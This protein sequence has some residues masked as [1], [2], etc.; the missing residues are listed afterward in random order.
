MVSL[1][2]GIVPLTNTNPDSASFV[3]Y[4]TPVSAV[5]GLSIGFDFYS[6]GGTGA[7]GISF[8]FIDGAQSPTKAG[9]FGG[10][11]GYAQRFNE[12]GVFE[13]G[14]V[15][16]YLGIGLDEYGNFSNPTEG[17]VG[18]RRFTPDSVAVR[19][20]Q[21]EN[22]KYLTGSSTLPGGLD[23][24]G[25]GA[26]RE[27]SRRRAQIT[28]DP[29]GLLTVQLD[30]NNN[31]VFTDANELIINQFN[32]PAV[33]GALPATFKFG[34]AASTGD[35][36]NIHEVGNFAVTTS[37]GTP[38]PGV[39]R[40]DL[41]VSGGDG[42]DNLTGNDGNDV[43]TGGGGNDTLTGNDGNDVLNGGSGA[44]TLIGGS[45]AD[46]WVFSGPT[47]AAALRMS[48]LRSLDRIPDFNFKQGDRFKL[49]FDNN[50][51]TVE[52]PKRLFNVGRVKGNTLLK[53]VR[54]AYADKLTRKRGNQPLKADEAIFFRYGNRTFVSVNNDRAPFSPQNDLL[55]EVTGIQY[56]PG[57][58]RP[59]SLIGRNYFV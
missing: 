58:A 16:G 8:F 3:L 55:A 15:G 41:V 22:Y 34:F 35:K 23:N 12:A 32:V 57:D 45:G 56:K 11:L 42:D 59:G 9:G 21:A 10:S 5:N 6:Y 24:P 18:G 46:L 19:G 30:L 52:R 43:L 26:T 50:L 28:L 14:V 47:K 4:T 53:A 33:N 38:V 17:R 25:A 44:D 39:F 40:G 1:A 36:T 27:T 7:D 20:S 13:P 49:D 2:P 31:G 29:A 54:T 37:S 51:D 48:T